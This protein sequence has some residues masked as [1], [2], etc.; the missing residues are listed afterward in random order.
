MCLV[1]VTVFVIDTRLRNGRSGGLNP[2]TGKRFL[3]SLKR[4]VLPWGPPGLLFS[5][6]RASFRGLG[7]PGCDV[8]NYPH[9]LPKLRLNG[10]ML[11]L[12]LYTFLTW[13]ETTLSVP[14][15]WIYIGAKTNKESVGV[16]KNGCWLRDATRHE[17]SRSWRFSQRCF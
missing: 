5:G 15:I 6:Y 16:T 17:I 2:R 3:T 1:G 14:L 9:R 11:V 13:T 8:E 10:V 12:C 4:L 7:R